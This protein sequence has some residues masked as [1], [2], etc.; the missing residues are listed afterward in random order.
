MLNSLQKIRVCFLNTST[1]RFHQR[2]LHACID[3][4]LS[5][6]QQDHVLARTSLRVLCAAQNDAIQRPLPLPPCHFR[7]EGPFE[8]INFIGGAQWSA[9]ERH[10]WAA[11]PTT[12]PF[13]CTT[14]RKRHGRAAGDTEHCR[15]HAHYHFHNGVSTCAVTVVRGNVLKCD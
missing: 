4:I 13:H 6:A 7:F 3:S 10:T 8:K 5:P 1:T 14:L 9:R 12:K 11:V 15:A 2:P